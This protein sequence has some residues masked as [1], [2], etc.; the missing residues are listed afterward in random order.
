M[1]GNSWQQAKTEIKQTFINFSNLPFL[2]LRERKKNFFFDYFPN[3]P[4]MGLFLNGNNFNEFVE[5]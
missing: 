5:F 1:D 3:F 2:F 4:Q